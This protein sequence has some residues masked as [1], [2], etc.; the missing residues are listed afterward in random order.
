MNIEPA[1][2]A[3]PF[4]EEILNK[5]AETH[6]EEVDWSGFL[7]RNKHHRVAVDFRLV[8]KVHL[9]LEFVL[10]VSHRCD[11]E[12]GLTRP[13]VFA[14]GKFRAS[15]RMNQPVFSDYIRYF[16]EKGRSG[17]IETQAY[18]IFLIP[19]G[20]NAKHSYDIGSNEL[21]GIFFKR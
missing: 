11:I 13:N 4:L 1:H 2:F 6:E 19:P 20:V 12:D 10:N 16:Q 3:D 7:T 14:V 15:D 21:L 8:T 5:M 18:L 17:I 9:D